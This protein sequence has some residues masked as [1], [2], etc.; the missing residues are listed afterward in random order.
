[1]LQQS[2]VQPRTS[3]WASLVVLVEKEDGSNRFCEDYRKP[4]L[5]TEQDAH[6]FQRV[7][8]LLDS[9][10]GNCLFSTLDIS[11]GY[12]KLNMSQED[13]KK[14]AFSTPNGLY[15]FLRMLYK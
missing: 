6:P 5:V 10:N 3:P 13:R 4:N 8:D 15:E 11:N 2:A 9:L 12:W 14:T 7:D 1:M